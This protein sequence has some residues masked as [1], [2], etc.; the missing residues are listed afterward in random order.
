LCQRQFGDV[1]R[2]LFEFAALDLLDDIDEPLIG[3][4]LNAA[5]FGR[6][7][8]LGKDFGNLPEPLDAFATPATSGSLLSRPARHRSLTQ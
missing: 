5:L 2:V 4:R 3:A 7:R 1:A 6:N 8:R